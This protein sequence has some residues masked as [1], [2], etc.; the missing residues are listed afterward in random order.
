MPS[1][2]RPVRWRIPL[3]LFTVAFAARMATFATV[4][5]RGGV[6]FFGNDAYYHMRRVLY[7]L[8]HFPDWRYI[9]LATPAGAAYG[10]AYLQTR[11]LAAPILTHFLVDAVWR[12]FFSA[13]T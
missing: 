4:F 3:G 12:L 9:L 7:G 10:L 2:A 6:Q 8:A 5:D 11:N 1:A 13:P